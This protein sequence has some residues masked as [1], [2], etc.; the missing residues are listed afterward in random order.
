MTSENN[1]GILAG[2]ADSDR[3]M[4]NS[5][6]GTIF[7]RC[8][9]DITVAIAV[10]T[11]TVDGELTI[12]RSWPSSRTHGHRHPPILTQFAQRIASQDSTRMTVWRCKFVSLEYNGRVLVRTNTLP[13]RI[14]TCVARIANADESE[15]A[16]ESQKET[17]RCT[18]EAR[19]IQQAGVH[20]PHWRRCIGIP[21]PLPRHWN[22][23]TPSL[24]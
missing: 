8:G 22:T 17:R 5:G 18:G 11:V 15:R 13:V 12:N 23:Q 16:H 14:Q 19:A 24:S 20:H 4:T 10:V 6:H 9:R 2:K 21:M 7:G 3:K 1:E